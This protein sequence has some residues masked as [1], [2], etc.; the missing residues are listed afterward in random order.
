M[1]ICTYRARGNELCFV[2]VSKLGG[3]P[4][5]NKGLLM[6]NLTRYITLCLA[7]KN[8]GVVSKIGQILAVSRI[9]SCSVVN[10]WYY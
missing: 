6:N 9:G 4:L 8:L 1:D 5:V 3:E 7:G 2:C 10:L